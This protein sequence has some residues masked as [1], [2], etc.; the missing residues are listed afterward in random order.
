MDLLDWLGLFF[1]FQHDNVKNQREHLVLHLANAHM[2]LSLISVNT[3]QAIV[4][5]EFRR[6][7]LKNYTNWCSYLGKASNVD[8]LESDTRRELLYVGLYLLFGLLHE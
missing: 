1:G 6:K 5:R 4:L 7:L 2:R 3:F 8:N